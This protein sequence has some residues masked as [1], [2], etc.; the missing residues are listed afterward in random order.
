MKP[1][2]LGK[3]ELAAIFAGSPF[4]NWL[5]LRVISVD[6]QAQTLEVAVP[7]RAEFERK[8][9]SAQWHGGPLASVIDTVGDFALGMLLGQGLPTINFRVDYLRPAINTDLQVI[10]RVRRAGRSVGVADVDV[11]NDSGQLV[12]IG[13]ASYATLLT[14]PE[15]KS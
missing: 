4:I 2:R 15:N 1:S 12:A 5:N 9:G 8:A 13:R 6:Y 11:F 7:M 14:T 10:A 3:D